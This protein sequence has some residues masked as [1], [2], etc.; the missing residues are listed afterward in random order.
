MMQIFEFLSRIIY[1]GF[2]WASLGAFLWGVASIVLSPCHLASIPLLIGF[3]DGQRNLSV[4]KAFLISLFFTLGLLITVALV[5]VFTSMAGRMLGDL[6]YVGKYLLS[7]FFLLFG[8]ILL[9]VIKMP[10]FKGINQPKIV[11]RG[12]LSAF[13]IG[14]IFGIGLGPCTFAFMA[15]MLGVV[16][17]V[18][19]TNV[20]L[21]IVLLTFFALGHGG[22]I[23]L[24]GTFAEVV[25][26]YL[27]WNENSKKLSIVKKICGFLVILGAIY[28]FVKY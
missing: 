20:L 17:Q 24:A 16:F 3:I 4:K 2:F 6:G 11:K 9:D 26:K 5:G 23:I 1:G 27:H 14:L 10:D 15:P 28:N 22:V 8:L 21:G 7:G 18:S 13:I 12:F 19:T 25:E